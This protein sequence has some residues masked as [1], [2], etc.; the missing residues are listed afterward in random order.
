MLANEA[1]LLYASAGLVTD[2]DCWKTD[3]S[4]AVSTTMLPVILLKF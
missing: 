4:E 1:G 3:R 2:F